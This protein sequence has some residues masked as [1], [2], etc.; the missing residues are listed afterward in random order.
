M[1]RAVERI[2]GAARKAKK[3]VSVYVGS[4]TEAVWLGTLGATVFVL[5]SDQ[6]FLRQAAAAGLREVRDKAG[7][8]LTRRS[9]ASSVKADTK[10]KMEKE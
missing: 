4:A 1:R 7:G 10:S 3:P 9:P 5:S 6:G 2:A 8:R